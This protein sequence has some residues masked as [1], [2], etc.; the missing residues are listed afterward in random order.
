ML[1]DVMLIHK[2]DNNDIDLFKKTFQKLM[3]FEKKNLCLNDLVFNYSIQ[4][5]EAQKGIRLK[6]ATLEGKSTKKEADNITALKNALA[7]GKHR[8]DYHIV[9]VYDGA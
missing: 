7:K 6:I 2:D 3:T 8:S 9:F 1:L 4:K 5:S